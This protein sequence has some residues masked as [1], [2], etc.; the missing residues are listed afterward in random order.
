MTDAGPNR[1]E[2]LQMAIRAAR[3]GQTQGARVMLRKILAED[4]RNERALL[5]MAK[6]TTDPQKRRQWLDR[7]LVVNPD[8]TSAKQAIARMEYETAAERNRT[9]LKIGVGAW[10]TFVL[11][12]SVVLYAILTG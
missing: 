3:N 1:E 2:L 8:N 10:V 9:L 4:K 7:V 6:L 5:W 11:V 12:G